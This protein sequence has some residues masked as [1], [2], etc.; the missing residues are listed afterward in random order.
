MRKYFKHKIKS[1][2]VISRIVSIHY[3]E[4]EEPMRQEEEHHDFW[5]A[6][7]VF[8]GLATYAQAGQ[9]FELKEGQMVFHSPNVSHALSC[10]KGTKIF[11][12][13]FECLSEAMRFFDAR[14]VKLKQRQTAFVREIIEIAKKT[15][16]IT[17]YNSDIELLSLLPQ[18]TLGGEQLIKNYLEMLLIDIMRSLTETEYGNDVFLQETE[19]NNKLAE[20][21]IKIL[22]AN[23][24]T[25]LSIDDIAKKISYSKAYIFRQFKSATNKSVMDYY[26]DLKIKAAKEMLRGDDMSV[27]EISEKLAF[28]SSNY[29]TKTFK[30]LTGLTPTEYKKRAIV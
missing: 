29:F 6:V 19:I 8:K 18:P 16:D 2:L 4:P 28:D 26:L 17:F 5:E 23:L 14:T 9:S 24:F 13:S 20:D 21:I 7:F 12:V 11:V 27:K 10:D 15:Y 22:K 3:L 25:R 30:K 1:L